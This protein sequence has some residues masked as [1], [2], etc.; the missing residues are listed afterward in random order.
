MGDFFD[1]WFGGDGS[2]VTVSDPG[3]EYNNMQPITP[4]YDTNY[5]INWGDQSPVYD[6]SNYDY[7]NNDYSNYDYSNDGGFDN[8]YGGPTEP[9]YQYPTNPYGGAAYDEEGN[10][11]PGYALDENNNPVWQGSD[12]QGQGPEYGQQGPYYGNQP[13]QPGQPPRAQQPGQQRQQ[14]PGQQQQQQNRSGG[15]FGGGNNQGGGS[16]LFGTLGALALGGGLGYLLSNVLS[17]KSSGDAGAPPSAIS[18]PGSN[19]G[20]PT[21]LASGGV[22]PGYAMGQPVAQAQPLQTNLGKLNPMG[23]MPT[24][25][26]INQPPAMGAMPTMPVAPISQPIENNPNP[27]RQVPPPYSIGV[28][29][30]GY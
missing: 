16:D 30:I 27:P 28:P 4:T 21:K 11:M 12:Y 5:D 1:N 9:I 17:G 2:S 22:N 10:L 8:G 14:Q 18:M 20:T 24:M 19:L 23:S 7:S 13:G 25:P 15:L 29:M 3:S 26:A 6:Y